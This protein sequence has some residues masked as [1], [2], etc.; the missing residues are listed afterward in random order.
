MPTFELSSDTPIKIDQ[1]DVL[2]MGDENGLLFHAMLCEKT[3]EGV[4]LGDTVDLVDMCPPLDRRSNAPTVIGNAGLTA[5]QKRKIKAFIDRELQE[6]LAAQARSSAAGLRQY[7]VYKAYMPPNERVS[8]WRYSCIGFV[9]R[10]YRKARIKLLAPPSPFISVEDIKRFY[11]RQADMLDKVPRLRR[12]GI[13]PGTGRMVEGVECWPV[14]LV[15]YGLHSLAR[16]P[17]DIESTPYRPVKGD[18]FYPRHD[19][20][21]SI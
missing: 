7:V 6:S 11:P 21:E 8:F 2:A 19:E 14:D 20:P 10:A 4:C 12:L 15:A 17:E 1:Y 9:L 5:K 3:S 16:G 18:E 13:G